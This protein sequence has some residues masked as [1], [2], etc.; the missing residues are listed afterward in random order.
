M[1]K[2]ADVVDY[3]I[4]AKLL[5]QIDKE[6]IHDCITADEHAHAQDK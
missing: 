1:A 2:M 3:K 6:W 5:K 4:E